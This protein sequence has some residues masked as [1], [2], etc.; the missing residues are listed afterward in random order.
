M[1]FLSPTWKY[2]K[3]VVFVMFSGMIKKE[4]WEE[5]GLNCCSEKSGICPREHLW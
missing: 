1:F 5:K 3:T 2:V 4:H